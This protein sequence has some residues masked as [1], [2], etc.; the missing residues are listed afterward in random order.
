LQKTGRL[1][2]PGWKRGG[3]GDEKKAAGKKRGAGR[4]GSQNPGKP[5]PEEYSYGGEW[6]IDS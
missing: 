6:E 5:V 3:S 1:T 2:R 4:S